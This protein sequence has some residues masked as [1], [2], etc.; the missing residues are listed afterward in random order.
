MVGQACS[1][2]AEMIGL[3]P[4]N[5]SDENEVSGYRYDLRSGLDQP[6]NE[7]SVIQEVFDKWYEIFW[8]KELQGSR[9]DHEQ[10]LIRDLGKLV[11]GSRI[12]D[13]ACA[14]GRITNALAAEGYEVTGVDA[15]LPLLESARARASALGLAVEYIAC[16]W[17]ELRPE[18]TYDCALLWFTS[19]GYLSESDNLKVLEQSLAFLKPQGRLLIET[20][21]WD[22][23]RRIFEPT[24]VR[25]SGED[26]LIEYHT[27]EPERGIQWTRQILIVEGHRVERE[28]GIRRYTFAEMR[29]MCLRSGFVEVRGYAEDGKALRPDSHRCILVA[30]K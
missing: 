23:M 10:R 19:F 15:S 16:D 18:P 5:E 9:L 21:H 30:R 12:I 14:F 22:R 8:R 28:Y 2:A 26:F 20:R 29:A 27:Y 4:T 3:M 24:T 13:L 17:R 6:L 1:S 7:G 11:P 25:S